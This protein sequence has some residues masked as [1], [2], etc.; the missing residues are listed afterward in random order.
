MHSLYMLLKERF[1]SRYEIKL[2][3]HAESFAHYILRQDKKFYHRLVGMLE[4]SSQVLYYYEMQVS[5][6]SR[7]YA[8]SAGEAQPDALSSRILEDPRGRKMTDQVL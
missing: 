8:V 3:S 7:N 5:K 6:G 1:S 2:I 4:F